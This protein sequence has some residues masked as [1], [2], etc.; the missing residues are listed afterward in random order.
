MSLLFPFLLSISFSSSFCVS[1]TFL[2]PF[3]FAFSFSVTLSLH[4][5]VLLSFSNI[6]FLYCFS[7]CLRDIL[8]FIFFSLIF[9]VLHCSLSFTIFPLFCH[10]FSFF[11]FISLLSFCLFFAYRLII[12]V[13]FSVTLC[14]G[15]TAADATCAAGGGAGD[16][17]QSWTTRQLQQRGTCDGSVRCTFLGG[18]SRE[19]MYGSPSDIGDRISLRGLGILG[20]CFGLTTTDLISGNCLPSYSSRVTYLQ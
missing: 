4:L 19:I 14:A 7:L 18:S 8:S 9:F 5:S 6:V 16:S 10:F 17:G 2:V 13:Y 15:G 11:I 3:L 12:T 20:G 1:F